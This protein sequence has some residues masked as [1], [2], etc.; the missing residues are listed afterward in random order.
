[1]VIL[2]CHSSTTVFRAHLRGCFALF[3]GRRC[4]LLGRRRVGPFDLDSVRLR[5]L[6]VVL[7]LVLVPGL[8]P[9]AA[10]AARVVPAAPE[11]GPVSGVPVF[12]ESAGGKLRPGSN[13]KCRLKAQKT[14][15]LIS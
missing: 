12:V 8:P 7:V 1:M 11:A 9:A 4:L 2:R 3:H 13:Y 10:A 15:S 6:L 14:E 5:L